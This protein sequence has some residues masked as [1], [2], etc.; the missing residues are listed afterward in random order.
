MVIYIRSLLNDLGLKRNF[1]LVVKIFVYL[2]LFLL[3][4]FYLKIYKNRYILYIIYN[5]KE[6]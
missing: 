5:V 6:L 2:W 4:L 3:I 1:V